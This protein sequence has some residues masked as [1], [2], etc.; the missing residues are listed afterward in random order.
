MK[1]SIC[2]FVSAACAALAFSQGTPQSSSTPSAP[3]SSA[4]TAQ[5]PSNP[6][7]SAPTGQSP[8]GSTAL[9]PRGPEAVTAQDPSRVVATIGGKPLTAREALDL[10]KPLPPQERKRFEANLQGLIQQ[11]YMEDQLADEATKMGLDQQSPWKEQLRMARANILTQAYLSKVASGT[12]GTTAAQSEDPKQYYDSHPNDFDQVKLGG[13]FIAFSPPGTPTSGNAAANR[14]E[15]QARQKADDLEKKLKA[16][17]DFGALARTESD[18]Q[19]LAAKGGELG[20]FMTG[21]AGLPADIKAAVLKME[22]GQIS[23]PIRMP[24]GFFI[25]KVESRT[26]QP[27]DQAR[28]AIAQR[29]QNEKNQ[30]AVKQELDKYK[31]EVKDPDFFNASNAPA[32]NIPSLQRPGGTAVPATPPSG[33]AASSTKPPA[34]P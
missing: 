25:L 34:Q 3:S 23:E 2:L 26:K 33:S 4:Q 11:I 5:K 14:T 1:S 30:A 7:G 20:T 9:K 27:F 29:L 16:N 18:N 8:A 6:S 13:I 10:L 19:Q 15:E 22:P 17:G 21:D 24:N 32:R 12:S 28:P 31:I